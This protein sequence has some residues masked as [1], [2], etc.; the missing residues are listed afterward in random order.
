MRIFV[1]SS[2]DQVAHADPSR[3]QTLN[4][5][6]KS[7]LKKKRQLKVYLRHINLF[8]WNKSTF[9]YSKTKIAFLANKLINKKNEIYIS[10]KCIFVIIIFFISN[11]TFYSKENVT[12]RLLANISIFFLSIRCTFYVSKTSE[13]EQVF[14]Y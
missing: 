8:H 9:K 2:T 4:A 5:F 1:E 11:E 13:K 3:D 14:Y 7:T 12:L 6:C 10:Q